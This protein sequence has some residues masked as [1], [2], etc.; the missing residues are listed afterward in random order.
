MNEAHETESEKLPL[1]P[2]RKKFLIPV[3]I[4]LAV[5]LVG[6]VAGVYFGLAAHKSSDAF[7]A[8]VAELEGHLPV[9]QY[10]GVPFEA[11]MVVLGKHDKRN[12]T[13]DLTFKISGTSGDAAVRSRCEREADDGPWEVTYLD[14]GV[15]GREDGVVFTLVGDPDDA[16]GGR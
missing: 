13:Y 15:G 7:T 10:V 5:T 4:L 2:R 6:A 12:R 11:G 8:T 3:I 9:K 1:L 14:I 16:P